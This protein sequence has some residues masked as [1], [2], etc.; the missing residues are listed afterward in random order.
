MRHAKIVATLGPAQN[1]YDDL[2]NLLAEGVN[3]ARFN[4]SHGTH[5]DHEERLERLRRASADSDSPVAVLL[6]LQGPK[7]RVG[8]FAD[9]AKPH[10]A[11]G[12]RFTIT[13]RPV[14]GDAECVSTSYTGLPGDVQPGDPLLI[15]DGRIRLRAVE[16]TDTDVVTEV[17]VPGRI[18]DHMGF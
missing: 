16:V 9:G 1:S 10:L 15:D 11:I 17:E 8:T 12:D 2:R 6:D 5:A 18:S 7:I 3:V 13:S 14:D 4:M